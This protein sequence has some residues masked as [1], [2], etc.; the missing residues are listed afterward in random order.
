M[1]IVYIL[2]NKT[3][4]ASVFP[5]IYNRKIS[6]AVLI[7]QISRFLKQTALKG[8]GTRLNKKSRSTSY[9]RIT[10]QHVDSL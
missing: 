5:S 9:Q 6:F 8:D 7:N 3:H 2:L 4:E 1:N 10:S